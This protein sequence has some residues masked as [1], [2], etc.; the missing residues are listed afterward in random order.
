M[1][2]TGDGADGRAVAPPAAAAAGGARNDRLALRLI[3]SP[4]LRLP[5][6]RAQ[7]E[8]TERRD[9]VFAVEAAEHEQRAP[10]RARRRTR[11]RHQAAQRRAR[12]NV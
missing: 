9:V 1:R 7:T 12:P 3:N 8:V 6:A 10:G 4:L 2:H 5:Q 11:H